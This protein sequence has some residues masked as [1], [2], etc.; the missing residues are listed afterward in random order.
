V[1]IIQ[2]FGRVDRIGSKNDFIK[3][4]NFWPQ[5][6]LEEYIRLK[7]RV[8]NKMTLVEITGEEKENAEQELRKLQKLKNNILDIE[9]IETGITLTD[10]SL[11]DFRIDLSSYI[12]KN[13]RLNFEEVPLGIH[14]SVKT[15]QEEISGVIYLLKLLKLPKKNFNENI[16]PY[17]L[18]YMNKNNEVKMTHLNVK[19]ILDLIRVTSRDKKNPDTL[20]VNIFNQQTKQGENMDYFSK[21]L[22]EA[23]KSIIN[24][25]SE[26]EIES[27]F[28]KGGTKVNSKDMKELSDFELV[29]FFALYE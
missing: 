7:Y 5:I 26:S 17:Y 1:R 27:I 8:E 29:S 10:I 20:G 12:Q 4:V 21:Q 24:V 13:P 22:S 14:A 6:E 3:L 23:I 28:E 18:I 11:N 16:H 15:N 9:D 19:K 25:N 2:R